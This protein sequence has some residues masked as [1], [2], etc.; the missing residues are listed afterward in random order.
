[1]KSILGILFAICLSACVLIGLSSCKEKTPANV[2][3]ITGGHDYDKENFDKL[4]KKLPITYDHV[5]HPQ[6]HAMLKADKIASY[7][8]ILLYDMPQEISPEAQQDFIAM[9]EK[10]K[11]LVV[12]HHAFCSYD[13]WPEYINIIGGKYHHFPWMENGV[14]QAPSKFKQDLTM[15]IKVEDSTH[16]ITKGITDFEILDEAYRGTQILSSVHPLLSTNE[17]LSGP[18]ICWTNTYGKSKVVTFTL[19]H[20]AKAWE[21]PSFIQVLS[22]AIEWSR[23]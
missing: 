18:L 5:E 13:L 19:G 6:A 12:L 1:M 2:L 8:A 15:Q 3:F 21:N 14:E 20:D 7:D 10:G 16:P 4:L 22:Q 17:P 11:G 23:K 9:L